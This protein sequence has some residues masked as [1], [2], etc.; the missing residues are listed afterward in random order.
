MAAIEL[1]LGALKPEILG[2]W[3]DADS[4]DHAVESQIL[5]VAFRLDR[6]RHVVLAAAEIACLGPG[7][8]TDALFLELLMR[9]GGNLFVLD[10]EDAVQDLDHR[11]L[12]AER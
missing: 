5:A 10:G 3:G 9:E 2:V 8:N 6:D 4:E 11:H 1:D 12:T 7:Q